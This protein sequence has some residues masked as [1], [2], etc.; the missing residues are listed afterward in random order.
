MVT[1]RCEWCYHADS[2]HYRIDGVDGFKKVDDFSKHHCHLC[3]KEHLVLDARYEAVK[4]RKKLWRWVI[5]AV[6]VTLVI[7][8]GVH[9]QPTANCFDQQT[10]QVQPGDC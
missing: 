4:N 2:D 1:V 8:W 6:V 9:K 5:V 10:G 7:Y 3:D